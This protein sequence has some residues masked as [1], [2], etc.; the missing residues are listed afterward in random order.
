MDSEGQF[1][2]SIDPVL[3]VLKVADQTDI[4]FMRQRGTSDLIGEP[5][6]DNTNLNLIVTKLLSTS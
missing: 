5:L 3:S 2:I 1:T 6:R 4:K